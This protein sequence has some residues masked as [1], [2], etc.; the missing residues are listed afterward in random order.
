MK[1]EMET[2]VEAEVD[3]EAADDRSRRV[4]LQIAISKKVQSLDREST[5][6]YGS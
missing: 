2:E 5:A 3:V 1:S 6:A 4:K